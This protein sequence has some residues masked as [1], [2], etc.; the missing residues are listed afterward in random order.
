VCGGELSP[1]KYQHPRYSDKEIRRDNADGKWQNT[2]TT[3]L[4]VNYCLF[5]RN[6]KCLFNNWRSMF[7]NLPSWKLSALEAIQ[8]L[9]QD[10]IDHLRLL[11][12]N[13]SFNRRIRGAMAAGR[14][15]KAS[16]LA[17][18]HHQR[19]L[20]RRREIRRLIEGPVSANRL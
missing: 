8:G 14:S 13:S 16:Y 17:V 15:T 19:R 6:Q 1:L 2:S 11:A 5:K 3:E 9:L 18:K 20:A 4:E 12:D 7:P 10:S